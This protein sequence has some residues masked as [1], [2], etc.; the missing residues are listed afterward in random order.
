MGG[1]D[2][3]R[4]LVDDVVNDLLGETAQVTPRVVSQYGGAAADPD[5][6]AFE[7]VGIYAVA[8]ENAAFR[9]QRQGAGVNSFANIAVHHPEF[10]IAAADYAA[11]GGDIRQG[12]LVVLD[13]GRFNV[14]EVRPQDTGDALLLLTREKA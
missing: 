1:F 8:P 10:W 11:V 4:D 12:D 5:R 7:V 3:F 14:S 6:D 13:A 9:G 2:Q